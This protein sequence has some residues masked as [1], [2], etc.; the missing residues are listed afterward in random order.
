MIAVM[1]RDYSYLGGSPSIECAAGGCAGF[2]GG[3]SSAV[4]ALLHS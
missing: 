4:I 3:S 2:F 1:Y